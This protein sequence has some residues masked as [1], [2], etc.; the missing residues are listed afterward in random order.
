MTG[1]QPVTASILPIYRNCTNEDVYW[2]QGQRPS[3]ESTDM[4][5]QIYRKNYSTEESDYLISIF[6]KM[7]VKYAF[8]LINKV[9]HPKRKENFLSSANREDLIQLVSQET[10]VFI[11]AT[12]EY[13]LLFSSQHNSDGLCKTR[14]KSEYESLTEDFNPHQIWIT[15]YT[16]HFNF[17]SFHLKSTRVPT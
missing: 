1:K 9:C 14:S 15:S 5:L 10:R 11:L 13:F 7:R 8:K 6:T 4:L 3:K 12:S 17:T 2:E 16:K